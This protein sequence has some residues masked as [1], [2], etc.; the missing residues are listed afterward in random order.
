MPRRIGD[1]A[2]T[3]LRLGTTQV[4]RRYQGTALVFGDAPETPALNRVTILLPA[5][6]EP[7]TDQIRFED[8]ANGLGD[9]SALRAD[10]GDATP[11]R[12]Q[13]RGNAGD[14]ANRVIFR[15]VETPDGTSGGSGGPEL[16]D[17][18][19]QHS[20]AITIQVPGLSDLV[21]AGPDNANVATSDSSEPYSWIPGSDY[22]NRAISY[23]DT[24][25]VAAGLAQWVADFKAAYGADNTLR[26]TLIMDDGT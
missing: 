10:E 22:D 19:E 2:V 23:T 16:S 8:L 7:V 11:V 4:V 18:W 9:V 5:H 13:I 1:T 12:L 15:L 25:A 3:G 17:E 20:E 14:G 6:T 21:L 26:A 24:N